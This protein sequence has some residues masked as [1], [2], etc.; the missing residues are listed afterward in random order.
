MM[1][2][3]QV[4]KEFL[5]IVGHQTK[6]TKKERERNRKKI[7]IDQKHKINNDVI[8]D[9]IDTHTHTIEK[10]MAMCVYGNKCV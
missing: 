10:I 6:Q 7:Q 4:I 8:L 1:M 9:V 5:K 2:A 3:K